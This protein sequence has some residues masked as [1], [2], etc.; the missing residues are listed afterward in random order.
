M[1]SFGTFGGGGNEVKIVISALDNFSSQMSKF[2]S[3]LD[4]LG[5]GTKTAS[6]ETSGFGKVM[7][8]VYMGIGISLTTQLASVIQDTLVAAI[9]D[10]VSNMIEM[11]FTMNKLKHLTRDNIAEFEELKDVISTEAGGMFSEKDIAKAVS[12]AKSVGVTNER[13]RELIP[14]LKDASALYGEDLT[15]A[16]T[17]VVRAAKFGEA[18]LAER[19]GLQLRENAIQ[20]TSIKLYGKKVDALTA[21]QKEEVVYQAVIEQTQQ[22]IG[23]EVAALET[24]AGKMDEL[25]ASWEDFTTTV[26]DGNGVIAAFI[27]MNIEAGTKS[28]DLATKIAE[29]SSATE[30]LGAVAE[31]SAQSLGEIDEEF[32]NISNNASMLQ[33][34]LADLETDISNQKSQL[35]K[36]EDALKSVEDEFKSLLGLRFAGETDNS[37]KVNELLVEE[38]ALKI[39][40]NRLVQEGV[41]D[42]DSRIQKIDEELAQLELQ[43]E[44]F[45]LVAEG[46]DLTR[47]AA[48]LTHDVVENY[49]NGV[50]ENKE[51]FLED[52]EIMSDKWLI[53]K[54]KIQENKSSVIE[55]ELEHA[56]LTGVVSAA[57]DAQV[58]KLAELEEAARRVSSVLSSIIGSEISPTSMTSLNFGSKTMGIDT[59]NLQKKGDFII[60]PDGMIESSPEDFIFGMKHPEDLN[61]GGGI[62]INI[63]NINGMDPDAVAE[64]LQSKLREV[65]TFK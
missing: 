39:E 4:S 45:E 35:E 9:Q 50:H 30:I 27:D 23:G 16:I 46:W 13:I 1:V 62:T 38:N 22:L 21:A 36:W 33:T 60:G 64:A 47:D 43:R 29:T 18:E 56:K 12:Y 54:A 24:I 59:S 25:K 5:S 48:E 20:Q 32:I 37:K 10:A 65:I 14:L 41:E 17:A 51:S 8:G 55:L 58:I 52:A 11:E 49:F 7:E 61:K 40:R 53:I 31:V 63:E 6:K 19:I 44:G 3:K 15:T 2:E 57:V 42:E 34:K 28:L 26:L